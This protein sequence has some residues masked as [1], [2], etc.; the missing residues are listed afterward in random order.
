M[1]GRNR[2]NCKDSRQ[3]VLKQADNIVSNWSDGKLVSSVIQ[4]D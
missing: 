2:L 1:N 3:Y 4:I